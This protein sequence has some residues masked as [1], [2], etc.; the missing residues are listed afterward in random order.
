LN[1]GKSPRPN[2]KHIQLIKADI[3][4]INLVRSL[5]DTHTFDVVVDWIAYTPEHIKNDFELFKD[6]TA[7]YIFISS[8]SAYQK[9]PAH[10][11]IKETQ[12]LNNP[13]WEYSQKKILC[14]QQLMDLYHRERFPVTIL[15]PS[16]T[17]DR[18]KIPLH[19][20][21]TTIDR[22]LKGKKI[23][24]HGDGTSLWT[25]THHRDFAK[26]FIG[27]LSNSEAIGEA[28]HITSDE[29]LTWNQICEIIAQT[30]GVEPRIIHIPSR[31]IRYFDK[32]WGDGLLGDKAYSMIFDNSKIKR[33]NPQFEAIIPF[34]EGAKEIISWYFADESRKH[35]DNAKN[36]IMDEMISRY[37]SAFRGKQGD[38][39][40]IGPKEQ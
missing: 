20:G 29:V 22:M 2:P 10:L 1:R 21:Y 38:D 14:E 27:L 28:Y 4:D 9:P 30:A 6:R 26:G 7:Q 12:P 8:A 16:H 19:G 40:I 13:F 32:D 3:R 15:R 17:Y 33:I 37:E 35:I 25:L 36:R 34:R 31:F 39:S 18:T 24:I 23:I 11:P 5:I